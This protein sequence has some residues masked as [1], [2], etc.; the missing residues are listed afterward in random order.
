MTA[1]TPAQSF[2]SEI[3]EINGFIDDILSCPRKSDWHWPSFYLLYVDADRLAMALTRTEHFFGPPFFASSPP[4]TEQLVED[5]RAILGEVGRHQKA[6]FARLY[7]MSRRIV[8]QPDNAAL[9]ARLDAHLHPKS[10][11]YQEFFAQYDAG[12][13]SPDGTTLLRTVLPILAEAPYERVD[14]ATAN[15]MLRRQRF[16]VST[17]EARKALADATNEAAQTLGGIAARMQACFLAHC[18]LEDLLYPCSA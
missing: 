18:K 13:F 2:L 1:H 8:R 5:S 3:G 7:P 11:W 12:T 6:I 10:G 17:P 4:T 15:C 16:D 9:H 14:H